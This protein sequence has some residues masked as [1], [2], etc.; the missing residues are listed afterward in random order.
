M[1]KEMAKWFLSVLTSS[2]IVTLIAGLIHNQEIKMNYGCNDYE[3][4]YMKG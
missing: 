2:S 3:E 4:Y 1:N